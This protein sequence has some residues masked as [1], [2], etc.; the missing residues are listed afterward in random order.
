M[1]VF[2]DDKKTDLIGET[3]VPLDKVVVPGGGQND[4]WHNLNCKGR[5]AG[6]I[7][8]ELTYYDTRAKEEKSVEPQ[9]SPSTIA[10]QE[11][12]SDTVGG[13]RQ[14]KQVKRR[15]LPADPISAS[16]SPHRPIMPDHSQSSPLPYTPTRSLPQPQD[17]PPYNVPV[18]ASF[19]SQEGQ[20][21]YSLYE[22]QG[23]PA[24]NQHLH[25]PY[26]SQVQDY[27]QETG[28]HMRSEQFIQTSNDNLRQNGYEDQMQSG[29]YHPNGLPY[30]ID[31]SDSHSNPSNHQQHSYQDYDLPEL[32]PYESR[33]S[34]PSPQPVVTQD[35]YGGSHSSPAATFPHHGASQDSYKQ[36]QGSPDEIRLRQ[37]IVT[38]NAYDSSPLRHQSFGE[39]YESPLQLP[40]PIID[41]DGGPPPPPPAHR[42]SGLRSP[43]QR[44]DYE[45]MNP[46]TQDAAP[47]PLNIRQNRTSATATPPSQRYNDI[48]SG[49]LML[50]ASPSNTQLSLHSGPPISSHTSNSQNGRRPSQ[51][52]VAFPNDDRYAQQTPPSL[53]AGYDPRIAEEESERM[54][55]EKRISTRPGQGYG[56]TPPYDSAS[57][58]DS[59]IRRSPVPQ[60]DSL[61]TNNLQQGHVQSTRPHRA[62]VPTTP[63][64]YSQALTKHRAS[65]PMIKPRAISPDPRTPMRKS[66][67][68][69]PES[70][71]E[72]KVSP[73]PFG[74]D[75][76]EEFNPNLKSAKSINKLGAKYNSPEEIQDAALDREREE[77]L[78]EGP[79]IGTD[80]RV[81][82]PSDHLPIENWAPEYE[83]KTFPRKGPEITFRFRQSP[84]G[85]Q[86]MPNA[87]PRPPRETVIRPHSIATNVH[88]YSADN[89]SPRTA[90]QPNRLQKKSRISMHP[91]SSPAVPTL[92]HHQSY[93]STPS[94]NANSIANNSYPLREHINYGHN[95][96]SPSPYGRNTGG[97]SPI[98]P[99]NTNPPPIPAKIPV[100]RGQEEWGS[101]A[102][103]EEMKRIDIGVGNG[104]G[105][106]SSG[107]RGIFGRRG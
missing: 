89:I 16:P 59:Q 11:R 21:P 3:W 37:P 39:E 42:S 6:D 43:L 71:S 105:T 46:Y 25:D 50:S 36:R 18:S 23:S 82:D 27:P 26:N 33:H 94:P 90:A 49:E 22:A 28:S 31:H 77:K 95:S 75:S 83:R 107:R 54:N 48:N 66:L 60:Y 88:S 47:A 57:K 93:S 58:Y 24:M 78:E 30:P 51:G 40:Q 106:G 70:H 85:A 44:N 73:I 97:G 20:S 8:I 69:Q 2:N 7:R 62:S 45:Q 63:D 10:S 100:H 84:Q 98:S 86:P 104:Y 56:A 17:T 103:S 74:P 53:V 14:L 99:A 19:S 72:T 55:Y 92:D 52:S 34:R 1:S 91:T 13:P 81:I 41:D 9:D 4:L 76:Y 87:S 29:P 12:G 96:V 61:G 64:N 5:Y 65:A 101:S 67:S 68:P 32:P 80:G 79:I 15:P 35:T 102:L 38:R